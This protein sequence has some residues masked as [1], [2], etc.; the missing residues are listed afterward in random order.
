[1][2]VNAL[3]VDSDGV[4]MT[5]ATDVGTSTLQRYGRLS[6]QNAYGSELLDLP[7][8]LTAEYWNG[9]SWVVNTDDQC[10]A[11]ISL[12]AVDPIATDGLAVNELCA[13]DTGQPGSSS[14]GCSTPGTITNQ[15]KQPPSQGD[16]NLNFKA[17]GAGNSG[18][19]DIT[20][21]VPAFLK[22]NWKGTGDT[23]P[24]A[25]ATFGIYSGNSKFIYIRELY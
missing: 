9:S 20:A 6:L 18:A 11:G 12:S 25:R 15:L 24:T 7:M 21:A 14:L 16:F 10:T 19:L 5:T 23:D 8:P 17:P 1:M 3:P 22:F 13:W 4:T 2:T